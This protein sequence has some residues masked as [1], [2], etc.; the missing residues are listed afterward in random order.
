MTQKQWMGKDRCCFDFLSGDLSVL[1]RW[2]VDGCSR[3]GLVRSRGKGVG[4]K[5][6]LRR[7]ASDKG[8][9]QVVRPRREV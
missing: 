6:S 4:V 7:Q 5:A 8:Q 1:G 2:R 9:V 3:E